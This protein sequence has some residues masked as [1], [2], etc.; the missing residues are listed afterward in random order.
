MV[1]IMESIKEGGYSDAFFYDAQKSWYE[2]ANYFVVFEKNF[3]PP[4]CMLE[5]HIDLLQGKIKP[6]K[7]QLTVRIGPSRKKRIFSE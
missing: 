6:K 7:D 2:S 4:L 1:C 3:S 5:Y